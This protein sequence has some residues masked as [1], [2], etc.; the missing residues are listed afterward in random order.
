M[1]SIFLVAKDEDPAE[2]ARGYEAYAGAEN[3]SVR[4]M[5]GMTVAL[6]QEDDDM[7][8]DVWN[9]YTHARLATEAIGSSDG[10]QHTWCAMAR[11][12]SNGRADTRPTRP[13]RLDVG[14]R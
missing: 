1:F 5:C 12:R 10:S 8:L 4:A 11:T 9:E 2:W 7:A 6:H 14:H 3:V 13:S